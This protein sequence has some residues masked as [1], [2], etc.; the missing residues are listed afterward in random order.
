MD[1]D[2]SRVRAHALETS[3]QF[4]NFCLHAA[5]GLRVPAGG[6]GGQGRKGRIFEAYY[7]ELASSP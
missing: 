6:G 5:C 3:Q 2:G 7:A 4:P 1:V